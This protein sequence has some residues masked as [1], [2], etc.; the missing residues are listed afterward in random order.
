MVIIFWLQYA[1]PEISMPRCVLDVPQGSHLNPRRLLR[2][3]AGLPEATNA[4]G[5]T[6]TIWPHANYQ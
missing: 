5:N 6:N 1:A 4:F 3:E 2:E